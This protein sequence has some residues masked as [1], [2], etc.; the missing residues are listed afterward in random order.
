MGSGRPDVSRASVSGSRVVGVA[1]FGGKGPSRF[2]GC[3]GDGGEAPSGGP[4]LASRVPNRHRS[5][6]PQTRP[7]C[8]RVLA[9]CGATSARLL[10]G[11]TRC[12][13]SRARAQAS[14]ERDGGRGP[15]A[16]C[17]LLFRYLNFAADGAS[18]RRGA[19]S[20]SCRQTARS[21]AMQDVAAMSRRAGARRQ[22][23]RCELTGERGQGRRDG[24][25]GHRRGFK[26]LAPG[27]ASRTEQEVH[28]RRGGIGYLATTS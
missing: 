15:S 9:S 26:R 2:R 6:Q 14:Y 13:K 3:L 4:D 5:G 28:D 20:R 11:S 1:A 16:G 19:R 12:C 10:A 17:A 27:G 24:S 7:L 25:G 18:C 23:A 22:G 21:E 8:R